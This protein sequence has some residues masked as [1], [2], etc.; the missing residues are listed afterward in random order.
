[1]R[2]FWASAVEENSNNTMDEIKE[3]TFSTSQQYCSVGNY[4]D[5]DQAK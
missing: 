3:R 2:A 1:M 5:N 4:T